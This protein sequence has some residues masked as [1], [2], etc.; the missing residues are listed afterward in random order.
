MKLN[1]D[2][3]PES[4]FKIDEDYVKADINKIN[5][6]LNG[7]RSDYFSPVYVVRDFLPAKYCQIIE[8]NFLDLINATSGGNRIEDFVKVE[9]VGSNQFQKTS[10]SY[11]A[12]C[13]RSSSA[14]NKLFDNIPSDLLDD[15]LLEKTFLNFFLNKNIHFGPSCFRANYCNMFTAR[16]WKNDSGLA[17]LPHEDLA[18]LEIAKQDD[19]EIGNVKNV[20]AQNLCVQNVKTAELKVWNINPDVEI[21]KQLGLE[22]T[23]YPYPLELLEEF[24]CLSVETH[25]GDLYFINANYVH[26]VTDTKNGRRISLGRFLGYASDNKVV[27]WT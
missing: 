17:L 6:M 7:S 25:P 20:V 3:I 24:K 4:M 5:K 19:Y 2:S 23:G 12:E 22:K 10:G 16:L 27:Y 8:E 13:N 14:V 21:K 1:G 26:A 15:F 11:M 18:Q 9:Q